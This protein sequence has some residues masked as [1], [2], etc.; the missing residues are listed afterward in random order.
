MD[1]LYSRCSVWS[2][3]KETT[4]NRDSFIPTTYKG[5]YWVMGHWRLRH[6]CPALMGLIVPCKRQILNNYYDSKLITILLDGTKC[7][8][9]HCSRLKEEQFAISCKVGLFWAGG[10]HPHRQ[11][12]IKRAGGKLL[13]TNLI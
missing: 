3:K 11:R 7:S 12:Q 2:Q 6:E 8:R 1:A 9:E 10:I 5:V 13:L 4:G